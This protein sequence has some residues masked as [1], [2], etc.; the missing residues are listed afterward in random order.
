MNARYRWGVFCSVLAA[1]IWVNEPALAVNKFLVDGLHGDIKLEQM[2]MQ[3][4]LDSLYPGMQFTWLNVGR[5]PVY[6]VLTVGT[7][8]GA[9]VDSVTVDV[10]AETQALYFV[11]TGPLVQHSG[12]MGQWPYITVVHPDQSVSSGA[13][14]FAHVDDPPPGRYVIRAGFMQSDLPYLVGIGPHIWD[15]YPPEDYDAVLDFHSPTMYLFTGSPPPRSDMDSSR[16]QS[17]MHV[18]GGIGLFYD[19]AEPIALKPIIR[20]HDYPPGGA[21]IR[22][23]LPGVLT[24]ALPEPETR[25]PLTWKVTRTS[26]DVGL[27]YEARFR[28]PLNFAWCAAGS[29]LIS[30]NSWATVHDLKLI[31]FVRGQGYRLSE[32]GTLLPGS[33]APMKLGVIADFSTVVGELDRILR[34][35][36]VASGMTDEETRTFFDQ[37]QWAARV[38]ARSCREPGLVGLYR[39]EGSDYDA[40]FPL[41][42]TPAPAQMTRVLWVDSYLP[43]RVR[44]SSPVHPQL[45]A[46]ERLPGEQGQYHEYGFFR[47]TY[48]GDALDELDMW[49]WHFYDDML[50]DSTNVSD[51]DGYGRFFFARWSNSIIANILSQGVLRVEGQVTGGITVQT[52]ADALLTGDEDC[53]SYDGTTFPDG[54]YPAVIAGRMPSQG[55]KI[56][57]T[58]DIAFLGDLGNNL[59]LGRNIFNWLH[60]SQT[61]NVPDIDIP[62]AVIF[63][64]VSEGGSVT[65]AVSIH[66]LGSA[67]LVFSTPLPTAT[68]LDV[69]GPTQ[70]TLAAGD[71]ATYTFVWSGVGLTSGFYQTWWDIYSNDP[72]EDSLHWPVLMRVG[73]GSSVDP[74]ASRTTPEHFNLLPPF[75]NPFNPST[76]LSFELA[77]AGRVSLELCNILGERVAT[78]AE[79]MWTA[80]RH[81]VPADLSTQAAGIYFVR[82]QSAEQVVVRKLVLLK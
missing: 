56:I 19:G 9:F 61:E 10:P 37:Y 49:G 52:P 66:N 14:G 47:E 60:R 64:A 36:A 78:L 55:G 62:Q 6:N 70:T 28:H 17:F 26:G 30:N 75:P 12:D 20:L 5:L 68:W 72:N 59:Q 7:F 74:H 1:A 33:K 24:Y 81:E 80:G 4:R 22:L 82:G 23:D 79:G 44:A 38:V 54:S 77:H 18:A 13:C 35:E 31:D 21:T 45:A 40:L 15:V 25:A 69:V 67:N 8:S 46:F 42:T 29:D 16:L 32:V 2:D 3:V 63:N 50:I 73:T 57:G 71:S 76:T 48:G 11:L 53:H 43:R 51:P 27:D 39:I 58:G 34:H 65:S 41:T